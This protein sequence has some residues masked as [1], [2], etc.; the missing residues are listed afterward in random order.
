MTPRLVPQKT[1]ILH[2]H[3]PISEQLTNIRISRLLDHTLNWRLYADL[4]F[5]VSQL[6][7]RLVPPKSLIL[8]RHLTISEQLNRFEDQRAYSQ[9]RHT[10]TDTTFY[11]LWNHVSTNVTSCPLKKHDPSTAALI[12]EQL[13]EIKDLHLK[14][15]TVVSESTHLSLMDSNAMRSGSLVKERAHSIPLLYFRRI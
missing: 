9:S 7:W 3:A 12:S 2:R 6:A 15:V 1:C 14:W 4:Y 11:M 13:T 10:Y 8:H 5:R